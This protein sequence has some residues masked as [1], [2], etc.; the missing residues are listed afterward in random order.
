MEVEG[1]IDGMS[2]DVGTRLK[3]ERA[4]QRALGTAQIQVLEES[5]SVT[6]RGTSTGVGSCS[7]DGRTLGGCPENQVGEVSARSGGEGVGQSRNEEWEEPEERLTA[8]LAIGEGTT[9]AAPMGRRVFLSEASSP[10]CGL[11]AAAADV[12]VHIPLS[13]VFLSSTPGS[14]GIGQNQALSSDSGWPSTWPGFTR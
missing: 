4:G 12:G 1:R 14:T 8:H 2:R 10:C 6:V 3:T 11:T 9:S 5:T 7:G 13:A